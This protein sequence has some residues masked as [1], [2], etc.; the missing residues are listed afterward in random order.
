MV[1]RVN[2]TLTDE[3]FELLSELA[4]DIWEKPTTLAHKIIKERLSEYKNER[5]CNNA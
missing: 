5:R 3:Q 2:L 1:R 4:D